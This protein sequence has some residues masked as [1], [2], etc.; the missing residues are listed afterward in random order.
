MVATSEH[1]APLP[2]STQTSADYP[3]DSSLSLPEYANA[4]QLYNDIIDAYES[5]NH[6]GLEQLAIKFFT[7][8]P[9]AQP[10]R[11]E[12]MYSESDE[13]HRY[14]AHIVDLSIKIHSLLAAEAAYSSQG[15][16]TLDSDRQIKALHHLDTARH[17]GTFVCGRS[18]VG[19]SEQNA[20]LLA[21][22]QEAD[23]YG[24]LV[25]VARQAEVQRIVTR[26]ARQTANEADDLRSP[27]FLSQY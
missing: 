12:A 3:T 7:K 16:L 19:W 4:C 10:K 11:T 23:G 18:S 27:E 14:H 8:Y 22:L 5:Y 26:T 6:T 9:V 15:A 24:P 21:R 25:E 13:L 20:H 17:L 2:D 1:T